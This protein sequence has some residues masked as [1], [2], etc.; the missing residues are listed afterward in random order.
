MKFLL[1]LSIFTLDHIDICYGKFQINLPENYQEFKAPTNSSGGPINV[2]FTFKELKINEVSSTDRSI[3]ISMK[4][5][6]KWID[7]RIEVSDNGQ[8]QPVRL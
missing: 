5:A 2:K 8:N 7:D 4:M 3:R 6:L 1:L